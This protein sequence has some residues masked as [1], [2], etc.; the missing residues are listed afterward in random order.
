MSW[1]T[2]PRKRRPR[3]PFDHDLPQ[4]ALES[5]LLTASCIDPG[6]YI[7]PLTSE[8]VTLQVDASPGKKGTGVLNEPGFGAFAVKLKCKKGKI[9]IKPDSPGV[10]GKLTL[11][12]TPGE[13]SYHLEGTIFAD[14]AV[15]GFDTTL[16]GAPP[17]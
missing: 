13:G 5:R 14:G 15:I 6:T 7:E 4:A 8:P 16:I 17:T 3:L 1:F 9:I 12:P 11:T 2:S 10:R